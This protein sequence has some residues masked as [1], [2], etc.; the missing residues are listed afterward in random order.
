MHDFSS[1]INKHQPVLEEALRSN[2]ERN[3]LLSWPK[4][5]RINILKD[6]D[7]RNAGQAAFEAHINSEFS[8]LNIEGATD[9]FGAE[10][11]PYG[12]SLEVSY[13][14]Q[15]ID[16]VVHAARDAIKEWRS[17]SVSARA[18]VLMECL[19][20]AADKAAEIGF[21]TMHTTGQGLIMAFQASGGDAFDRALEAVAMGYRELSAFVPNNVWTKQVGRDEF[22]T[23]H[24][25]FH[26]VPRGVNLV[27]GCSTFP[28]WNSTPGMFAG[29]ITGNTVVVKP[30]PGAIL[31]I[32]IFV[33]SMRATL[34][35]LGLNHN[36]VQLFV[37]TAGD[38][39]TMDLA[40]HPD[41]KLIDYTG[42]SAFGDELEKVGR[43]NNKAVFTEKSGVN[44]VIIESADDLD[45][46]LDNLAF[47]MVLY[48][49]QMCTAPQTIFING[50]GVT[51]G[52]ETVP[53]G[54]VVDRLTEKVMDLSRHPKI[55][56]ATL[57]AL[58]NEATEDR[59]AAAAD[60]DEGRLLLESERL[61]QPGFPQ[62]RT[63]T[64]TVIELK[65]EQS[66]VYGREWF[67][68][69]YFVV[70]TKNFEHSLELMSNLVKRVGALTTSVYST[71]AA[72]RALAEDRIVF[73][74]GAPLAFNFVGKLWVN[75]SAA[76]SDF[77]GAGANPA[78]SATFSD[79]S[80][81][82]N[83]YHMVG[84]RDMTPRA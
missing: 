82:A 83:R 10:E 54:E 53:Y 26:A 24:K 50:S 19:E 39:Q 38:P 35:D 23:V 22:V 59:V 63:V 5:L 69:V 20:R 6:E 4:S 84:V 30:H 12:F 1:L 47:S 11:S 41:V 51:V 7:A 42:S 55:G 16:T 49:G 36:I 80:F 40:M 46:V 29:L 2:A 43:E 66:D 72:Q 68:P 8:A 77:H 81:I 62:A 71:D 78:G 13:P 70:P 3:Q 58:Q 31:P 33:A 76:F 60:M 14:L 9:F 65:A 28:I 57:G 27:V 52:D 17:L 75:Q 48:S 15:D 67:G 32:A 64:P 61:G 25:S 34:A 56:A 73:E 44:S 37:D 21:A 45:A 79:V 74:A 18:A